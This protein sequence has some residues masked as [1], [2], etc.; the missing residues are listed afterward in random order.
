MHLV[1]S[2][3]IINKYPDQSYRTIFNQQTG[4]LVRLEDQNGNEPSWC[5]YGPELMDISITNWCDRDCSF[6][7]KKSCNTGHHL[8]VEKYKDILD[9]AAKMKVVQVALGGGNP[10]Q[11][12]DFC[13]MLSLTRQEYNIVPSYTT[14]GRGLTQRI[15]RASRKYCGAVAVSAYEPFEESFT[16]VQKLIDIGIKTNIHFLLTSRTIST[17]VHWLLNPPKILDQINAIVFLNYKP[18][19]RSPDQSLLLRNSKDIS[20]FFRLVQR[21][22]PF[23]IGFDSCTISGIAKNMNVS[24]IF[25]ECCEAGRFSMYISE[26]MKMYPCSF[27]IDKMNGID[28]SVGNIQKE[29]VENEV[30]RGLREKTNNSQC[31]KCNVVSLCSG[32]C[33]IF[34]E[35]N[36]CENP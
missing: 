3:I 12:P 11:H 18:I 27:M 29:W 32:G 26:E 24:P 9:Q 25:T 35:I 20:T 8:E 31:D 22:Y 14:N 28:V 4:F 34:P 7:Y 30:F 5:S 19:G 1:N 36:L 15:L 6:C 16:A 2:H 17:A 21:R 23:K 10:N 13:E 33:R